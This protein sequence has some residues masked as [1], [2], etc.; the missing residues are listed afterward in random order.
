MQPLDIL[1][2]TNHDVL[3]DFENHFDY[4]SLEALPERF[5]PWVDQAHAEWRG[6]DTPHIGILHLFDGTQFG[7]HLCTSCVR[8][9]S[10]IWRL[11]SLYARLKLLAGLSDAPDRDAMPLE[12]ALQLLIGSHCT[13]HAPRLGRLTQLAQLITDGD[14]NAIQTIMA[15]SRTLRDLFSSDEA[16]IQGAII[17]MTQ[18][19]SN[20]LSY[21]IYDASIRIRD[22]ALTHR[23]LGFFAARVYDPSCSDE[24]FRLGLYASFLVVVLRSC[25]SD[26]HAGSIHGRYTISMGYELD[27]HATLLAASAGARFALSSLGHRA[28]AQDTQG[29]Y[30][31]ASYLVATLLLTG[32]NQ[33]NDLFAQS[34]LTGLF[35]DI[36]RHAPAPPAGPDL[37]AFLFNIA[38][39]HQYAG[40]PDRLPVILSNAVTEAHKRLR[41]GRKRPNELSLDLFNN[42]NAPI[43]VL[44][45]I[46]RTIRATQGQETAPEHFVIW[47]TDALCTQGAFRDQAWIVTGQQMMQFAPNVTRH[48]S[49]TILNDQSCLLSIFYS[50]RTGFVSSARNYH[51]YDDKGLPDACF[52]QIGVPSIVNIHDQ[53]FVHLEAGIAAPGAD[54]LLPVPA[55]RVIC[56]FPNLHLSVPSLLFPDFYTPA[57][58]GATAPTQ[59]VSPVTANFVMG[60]LACS[61][62]ITGQ[63]GGDTWRTGLHAALQQYA[64]R[65]PDQDIDATISKLASAFLGY[66]LAVIRAFQ[67]ARFN[68]ATPQNMT[69]HFLAEFGPALLH[70]VKDPDT[71][72]PIYDA[73]ITAFGTDHTFIYLPFD[74]ASSAFEHYVGWSRLGPRRAAWQIEHSSTLA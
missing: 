19:M 62:L 37:D 50:P 14:T 27:V 5:R 29:R 54:P 34:N 10:H 31:R 9:L 13:E 47:T 6:D 42:T 12:V 43:S 40:R 25:I 26:T 1:D 21:D 44:P 66:M 46:E 61:Y 70:G 30:A 51:L 8:H 36:T 11:H 23:I 41:S 35:D 64:R 39:R 60:A 45:L 20:L 38:G 33:A 74:K 52:L 2:P 16:R 65:Y 28:L 17:Y 49:S 58:A 73:H 3:D 55:A 69:D 59:S 7:A 24:D 22:V 57:K 18:Q 53:D 68:S 32:V 72:Q 56:L 67:H 15:T 4:A 48:V 71:V 63:R